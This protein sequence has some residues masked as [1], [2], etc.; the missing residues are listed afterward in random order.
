MGGRNLKV[1]CLRDKEMDVSTSALVDGV[2]ECTN[3]SYTLKL[4]SVLREHAHEC[5]KLCRV[6][7]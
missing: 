6:V 7:M 1:K 4:Q 5:V 3:G 2:A